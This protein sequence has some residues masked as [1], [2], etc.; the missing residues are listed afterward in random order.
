MCENRLKMNSEKTEFILCESRQKLQQCKS[1]E[2][3]VNGTPVTRNDCI[4]YLGT[5]VDA[6]LSFKVNIAKKCNAAMA[7]IR[8]LRYLR[9]YM[10]IEELKIVASALVLSYL[11]YTNSLYIGLP[12]CDISKLQRVQNIAAKTILKRKK[13]DSATEALKELHW[14]PIDLRIKF[15]ILCFVYKCLDGNAPEYLQ[16]LLVIRN[17]LRSLRSSSKYKQLVIPLVRKSTFARRS[18]SVMG[19]TL[20]NNIPD[21]IKEAPTT[22]SFKTKLK[23]YMF[24]CF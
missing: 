23:T 8:K 12:D 7:G 19:P 14:L 5:W 24:S 18:F 21:E 20:W 10:D 6:N 1:D 15:K 3:L 16:N 11:D 9:D 4:K 22:D 13:F 17:Q 2:L